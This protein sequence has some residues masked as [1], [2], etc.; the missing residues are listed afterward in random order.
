MGRF[1]L[2]ALAVAAG[3]V[4]FLTAAD[5]RSAEPDPAGRS[6]VLRPPTR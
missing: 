6:V 5:E 2:A 3:I 4:G 1:L